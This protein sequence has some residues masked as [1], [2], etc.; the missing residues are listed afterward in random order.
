ML[1]LPHITHWKIEPW[2]GPQTQILPPLEGLTFLRRKDLY[3]QMGYATKIEFRGYRYPFQK[4][5][6]RSGVIVHVKEGIISLQK[7]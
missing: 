4:Q 1:R 5:N 6:P 3:F 2:L 7:M